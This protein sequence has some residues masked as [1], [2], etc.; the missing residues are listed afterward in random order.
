MNYHNEKCLGENE[1]RLQ[2]WEVFRTKTT[3][4]RYYY[5]GTVEASRY[6]ASTFVLALSFGH[7]ARR[8]MGARH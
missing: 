5:Y 4:C 6:D 8:L 7:G 3:Y 1:T 2:I